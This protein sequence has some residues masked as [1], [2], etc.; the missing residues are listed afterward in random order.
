MPEN[1]VK[2]AFSW[3]YGPGSLEIHSVQGCFDGPICFDPCVENWPRIA[4]N[5]QIIGNFTNVS[6]QA[7]IIRLQ[8]LGLVVNKTGARM[9]WHNSR[10]K[11]SVRSS[12]PA[13]ASR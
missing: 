8:D 7:I 1:A 2:E 10:S 12:V 11:P 13:T 5:V 4:E 6:K 3:I 9:G